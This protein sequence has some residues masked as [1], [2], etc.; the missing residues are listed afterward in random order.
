MEYN[1]QR[2]KIGIM[3]YGRN[4]QKLIE[5][6]KTI[7][8]REKR[9][10]T[11]D[12]I[13]GIMAQVN[14][15]VRDHSDYRR[16]L[17]DHLMM[18][19]GGELDVDVPFEVSHETAVRFKPHRMSHS[20]G[21]VHYRHYGK[22]LEAMVRRVG[23]YEQGEERSLLETQLAQDMKR[24]YLTWN[25]DTVEDSVIVDQ[26]RQMSDGKILLPE[27]SEIVLPHGGQ[28][29]DDFAER[30]KSKKKKKK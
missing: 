8:D 17:W 11:A 15:H 1:T 28:Q 29:P 30:K 26:M 6:A 7:E 14:P 4:V 12:A 25:R 16:K 22:L 19:A 23:D 5:Y 20:N 10:Q 24:A 21:E 27:D 13:I 9:N 2:E 18:L 3:D